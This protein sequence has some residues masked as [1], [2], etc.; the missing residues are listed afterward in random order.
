MLCI[1]GYL[2]R[3]GT[4]ASLRHAPCMTASVGHKWLV[5]RSIEGLVC[6]LID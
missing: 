5:D 2:F 6:L 3:V 1:I 4:F